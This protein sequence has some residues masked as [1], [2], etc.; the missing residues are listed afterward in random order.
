MS[1]HFEQARI[2]QLLSSYGPDEP[3]RLPLGFGD[4]L[5]LLWRL[6]YHANDLGKV[7]YYRRAAD[8]LT[9]GLGI[10]DNIVLRFIEHAQPGDLYSQL[11]NVPYR[12]S[13]RLVDANDRKAAIAQ[14]AALRN[15]IMR[16]GNYPS[17]WTMGWP[18]SGI[19]DTAIRERVFAVLF[20][21]LQSQYGNFARLLLV[22]DIVLSDLLIDG[23]VS[24]EISLHQLVVE[25]GFPNP[26]DDRVRQNYYEG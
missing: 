11:S 15:D 21:A 2:S 16:V 5:S 17:Q 7:R 18:G 22:I 19:E 23:D 25:F 26:H 6:D 20:T 24:Q 1:S 13:R 14:L 4:Y 9:S 10:R 3:P 8:A 12:G